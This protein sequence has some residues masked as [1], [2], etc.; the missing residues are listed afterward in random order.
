M[1]LV[2]TGKIM[3]HLKRA[4]VE[5]NI[6]TA[7]CLINIWLSLC[8]KLLLDESS[9]HYY[10]T[11]LDGTL[12]FI[13]HMSQDFLGSRVGRG[14]SLCVHFTFDIRYLPSLCPFW[15]P[16]LAKLDHSMYQTHRGHF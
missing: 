13:G 12:I 10:F 3:L 4:P 1:D 2:A 11:K 5:S 7:L 6:F 16:S 14:F 15:Y 8:P 9:L